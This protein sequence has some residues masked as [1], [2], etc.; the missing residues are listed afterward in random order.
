MSDKTFSEAEVE[1]LVQ[2]KVAEATAALSEELSKFRSD[3]QVAEW[4]AKIAEAQADAEAKVA[5]LQL[6]LDESEIRATAAETKYDELMAYLETEKETAEAAAAFDALREERKNAV[7]ELK[8]FSEE[9]VEEHADRWAGMSEEIFEASLAD[10][11]ALAEKSS[12]SSEENESGSTKKT[13]LQATRSDEGKG[14]SK[15]AAL[16][17]LRAEGVDPRQL[18]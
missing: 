7:A 3:E 11:K 8:A 18:I 1:V 12:S 6:K 13:A 4:E 2:A 17:A 10:Y 9:Y 14:T 5:D 15:V 16:L